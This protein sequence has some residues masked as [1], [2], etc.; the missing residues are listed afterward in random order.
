MSN[1]TLPATARR[2]AC[3]M[4]RAARSRR[5]DEPAPG[6]LPERRAP[7]PSVAALLSLQRTAG[8]QAVG[9]MLSRRVAP[10][11]PLDGDS[12]MAA[13]IDAVTDELLRTGTAE[14]ALGADYVRMEVR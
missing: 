14:R 3:A 12:T 7:L 1:D 13:L 9:R 10:P 4:L 11:T 2:D 5:P 8:N 6:V